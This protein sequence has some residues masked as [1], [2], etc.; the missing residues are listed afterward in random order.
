ML[1][2]CSYLMSPQIDFRNENL[3]ETVADDHLIASVLDYSYQSEQSPIVVVADI[4]LKNKLKYRQIEVLVLTD[5]LRL[6]GEPHPLER[7]NRELQEKLARIESRIP[8]LSIAFEG[9]SQH[10]VLHDRDPKPYKVKSLG[11]IKEE[12]PYVTTSQETERPSSVNAVYAIKI[13]SRENRSSRYNLELEKYFSEYQVYLD[14]YSIWVEKICLHHTIKVVIDN[15]GTAPASIVDVEL[16]F[17]QGVI[18]VDKDDIPDMPKPPVAPEQNFGSYLMGKT[19]LDFIGSFVEHHKRLTAH[20][21]GVPDI[22]LEQNAIYI[23]YSKL[24]HGFNEISDHLI[25]RFASRDAV[26]SFNIDYRLSANEIPDAV[27]GKLN[28]RI[29]DIQ[30]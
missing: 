1:H 3:S 18:P 5:D 20:L 4:G 21:S 7:E 9:G 29:D 13:K 19:N 16:Y 25:F 10:Q 17:P 24:K 15:I 14:Q 22:E 26:G 27:E 11:Q 2:G 12:H 8:K 23:S 6:P 28:I 30:Q